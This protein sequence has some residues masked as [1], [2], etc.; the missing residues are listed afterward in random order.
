V[1]GTAIPLALFLVWDGVILG[2]LP[3]LAGSS[4]VSDPLEL[5]RSSN[6]IVGVS[7][8]KFSYRLQIQFSGTQKLIPTCLLVCSLLLRRSH[9]SL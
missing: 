8:F 2:T 1:A 7:I 9:F 4:T 3:D 6:G 5:L